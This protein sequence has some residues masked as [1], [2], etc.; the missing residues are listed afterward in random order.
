ME[1]HVVVSS[2]SLTAELPDKHPRE[3]KKH[4]LITLQDATEAYMVEV[5][6]DFHC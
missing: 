2:G 5:T 1:H 4:V 3:W 6:A